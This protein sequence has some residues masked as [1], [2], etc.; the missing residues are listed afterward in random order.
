MWKA[1]EP[2]VKLSQ[3][4]GIAIESYGGQTPVVRVPGGPLD[5]T[6][7][8]IKERLEKTYGKPVT[9]GQVLSKWLLQKDVIVVTWVRT[10]R[11]WIAINEQPV[12]LLPKLNVSKNSWKQRTSL[13]WPQKR[14]KPLK[15]K[16]QSYTRE[17]ICA[18]YLARLDSLGSAHPW[19]CSW[20]SPK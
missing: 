8:S 16:A 2:I 1:A 20:K 10:N 17:S 6:L 15:Q 3:S 5:S 14:F 7:N 11:P 4:K 19:R 18:T 13:T 9:A 12:V